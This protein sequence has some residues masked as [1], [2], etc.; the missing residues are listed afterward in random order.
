MALFIDVCK[1][2]D[3]DGK[4]FKC[5][6]CKSKITSKDIKLGDP[7]D[8]FKILTPLM[9][10]MFINKNGVIAGG[11]EM[12]REK[13]GDKVFVCGHCNHVHLYGFDSE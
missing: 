9:P 10:F 1:Q 5:E 8:N 11:Y 3:K 6:S 7:I 4:F 13:L 2:N 12:A